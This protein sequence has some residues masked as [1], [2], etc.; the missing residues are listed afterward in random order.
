MRFWD[1]SAIVPLVFRQSSSGRITEAL[2][3]DRAMTVW[4]GTPLECESAIARR[5]REGVLSAVDAD[6]ARSA[7]AALSEGWA[8]IEPSP[9]CRERAMLLLRRYPI[10]AADA[11]QLAAAL[12]WSDGRPRDRL[13]CTLDDRLAM[14]ARREG[15]TL[16]L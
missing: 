12:V 8:E 10:R 14:T 5:E 6:Q 16:A 3:L 4:W 1:A 9:E 2:R 15:F 7:L 11:S 13:L